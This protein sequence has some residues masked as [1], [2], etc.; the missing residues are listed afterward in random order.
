MPLASLS[1]V[2]M[3]HGGP[4]LLADVTLSVE[5]GARIG[6][7][8]QNGTGKS[9]LLKLLL[10][11]LEPTGGVVT[12][13]RGIRV[14]YQAQELEFTA[15][16][17]VR[18]EMRR[19]FSDDAEREASIAR[20]EESLAAE[21]SAE[22]MDRILDRYERLIAE[23]ESRGVYDIDH[24]IETLLLS[25]GFPGHALDQ[26]VDGLSGGERN[27]IGLARVLLAEPHL[28]LLDE[29]S[30]HLDIAGTEWFI[31][32][33]RRTPA[34]FVMVSHDRH[35]LD[36]VV[37]EV[38][39]LSRQRVTVWTG[40]YGD[41]VQQKE[42]S[43]A[44][45]ER[46]YRTQQSQ[47]K[48]LE[49]Q[50]R[51]Y[52]DMAN[53]YDDPKQAKRAKAMMKRIEQMEVV[54]RPDRSERRFHADLSG[55]DRHG[56]IALA[57]RDFDFAWGERVLFEGA[58][59]DPEFGE[60]VC[61]VGP[62]GSGKTTLLREV[63]THGSW[64]NPKLRLGKSV[65]VGEYRQLHDVLDGEAGVLDFMM[66]IT[67]LDRTPAADLL[68]RFLFRR[69]DLDRPIS[70]LSGGE[71]SRLQ[72]ARLVNDRVNL[73]VMDEPTN[74]LDIQACEVLEEML[75]EFA[76]T[77]LVVSHDR[78]FL[79][80]LVDR[81]VEVRDRKLLSHRIGFAE[82]WRE[83]FTPRGEVRRGALE[84]R[85][86]PVADKER[87]RRDYERQREAQREESRRASRL[88]RIEERIDELETREKE[89]ARLMEDGYSTGADLDETD[90][91]AREY[92]ELRDELSRL[93]DEWESLAGG[94]ESV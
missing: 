81:V 20:I 74:H 11:R 6:L 31:R 86:A 42:E 84:D 88:R 78:Y 45:Q 22:E 13:Q 49:F 47:I 8:G 37:D 77:L 70:T 24:R 69:E 28:M 33:L 62:N 55:G 94:P 63:L 23:R 44:L 79:D 51:R 85:S 4:T 3:H 36:A 46:R 82:W 29:P 2:S 38:W 12:R 67:G 87:A 21:P 9:T 7:I 56:R 17:T 27:I 90:R 89:L 75:D 76:G 10:G 30:N 72:L 59:L 34:A 60:R 58:G 14:A 64:E 18:E 66:R 93:L 16:R 15:G 50:A 73:L 39:E 19:A 92:Q 52:R 1:H 48:R 5:P 40:N 53:A 25:L 54:D 71:K 83:E 43:L 57:I 41:F 61:L 35:V 32:F 65:K 91:L 80:R 26:A 68:H